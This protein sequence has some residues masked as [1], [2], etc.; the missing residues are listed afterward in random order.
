M[1]SL[2]KTSLA[3]LALAISLP[4]FAAKAEDIVLRQ[5]NIPGTVYPHELAAEL[6][7]FEKTGIKFESTGFTGSGPEMLM[8]LAG[9]SIELAA[10]ATPAILNAIAGGNDFVLAYPSS[11]INEKVAS[12]FYVRD[13]SPIKT[14]ADL[15]G[16]S[17][18]VNTLGGHLDYAIREAL[19]KQGL[20]PDAAN[21]IVVPGPQLEQTLRSEQVDVA[22][23]GFWQSAFKGV[24]LKSGGLRPVFNDYD[25]LGE[26][27]GGFVTLRRDWVAA[28]PAATKT[29]IEE[30]IRAIA[31]SEEHPE[32]ARQILARLLTRRGENGELASY[33]PGYGV[34]K[35]GQP[36]LRDLEFWIDIF[37]RQGKLSAGQIDPAK[38]LISGN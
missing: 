24:A 26:L 36:T 23:F 10:P 3:I 32:E 14:V 11:G 25:A 34:R 4:T 8:A 2:L 6:G 30:S 15:P 1:K 13:N 19:Q 17:I 31:W 5:L 7:Y 18:A 9:G 12:S 29:F 22:A 33:F 16:K 37:V 27:S 21:L 28:H 20:A 38:L 35:S